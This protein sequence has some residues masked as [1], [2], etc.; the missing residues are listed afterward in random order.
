MFDVVIVGAGVAGLQTAASLPPGVSYLILEVCQRA[1]RDACH[2]RCRHRTSSVDACDGV[3]MRFC[4]VQRCWRDAAFFV[5]QRRRRWRRFG[6]RGHSRHHHCPQPT[7]QRRWHRDGFVL[8]GLARFF[9]HVAR[10]RVCHAHAGD[11][12]PSETLVNG[13][14]GYYYY[15]P[16]GGAKRLA[17]F[18]QL[19]AETVRVHEALQALDELHE[20]RDE[21]LRGTLGDYLR[22]IGASSETVALINA[23]YANTGTNAAAAAARAC[24]N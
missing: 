3:Q 7:V 9:G 14:A 15:A 20:Q 10:A 17:R 12:G 4:L 1:L 22:S 24:S 6:R 2:Q 18:D 21:P 13:K 8:C 23:G 16:P 19:D 11:G 5:A